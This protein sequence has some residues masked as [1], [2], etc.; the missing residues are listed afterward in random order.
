MI[1]TSRVASRIE[2]VAEHSDKQEAD[3]N[4]AQIMSC[5]SLT[6]FFLDDTA[7]FGGRKWVPLALT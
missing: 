7:R 6:Y 3:C 4:H 1:E 5:S 2:A